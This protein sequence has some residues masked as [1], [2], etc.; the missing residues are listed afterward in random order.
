[1]QDKM[2]WFKRH[3]NWT[4]GLGILIGFILA[5]GGSVKALAESV[6]FLS[7]SGFVAS[8]LTGLSSGNRGALDLIFTVIGLAICIPISI[9]VLKQ[10][11]RTS[12]WVL[13][14]FVPWGFIVL[15]CLGN[16]GEV[17]DIVDSKV[18]TRPRDKN[19]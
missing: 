13:M 17:L 14:V 5:T 10:K 7:F 6:I 19:D 2:N 18:I 8:L 12:W 11:H 15:P 9:W 3:L 4:L 16:R 1:M